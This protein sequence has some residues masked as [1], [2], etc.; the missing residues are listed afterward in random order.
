MREVGKRQAGGAQQN[1]NAGALKHLPV[2]VPPLDEQVEIAAILNSFPF[3]DV[4][5][6]PLL[7]HRATV[8]ADL[9][10]GRVRVPA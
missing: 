3:E 4:A 5:L 8:R 7:A 1:L 9:L 6:E 2:P 10:S